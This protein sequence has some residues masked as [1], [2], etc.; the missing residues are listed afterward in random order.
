MGWWWVEGASFVP[1]PSPR[2]MF[3]IG[4]LTHSP[5]L[6]ERQRRTSLAVAVAV[7]VAVVVVGG[8]GW[9]GVVGV[10]SGMGLENGIVVTVVVVAAFLL[11][12][13]AD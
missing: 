8:A 7:A 13:G 2:K 11:V 5:P 1:D 9:V 12:G 10:D 6:C 4:S 3:S